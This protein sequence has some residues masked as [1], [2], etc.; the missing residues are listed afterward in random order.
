MDCAIDIE[1]EPRPAM[2][3]EMIVLAL[4]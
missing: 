1:G 2:L 4:E 3:A